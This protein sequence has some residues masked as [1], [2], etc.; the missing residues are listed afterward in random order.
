[1]QAALFPPAKRNTRKNDQ[2][3]RLPKGSARRLCVACA[4][5]E[6][7]TGLVETVGLVTDSRDR[8]ITNTPIHRWNGNRAVAHMTLA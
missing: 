5:A 6:P 3:L 7:R 8:V 2:G 4:P 1:M